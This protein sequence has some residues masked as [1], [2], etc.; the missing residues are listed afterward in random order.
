MCNN[1]KIYG[2]SLTFSAPFGVTEYISKD[3]MSYF[4]LTMN[5]IVHLASTI[6]E[7]INVLFYM[8]FP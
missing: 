7:L 5:Y 2:T 1:Y 4:S 3:P 8:T 6:K